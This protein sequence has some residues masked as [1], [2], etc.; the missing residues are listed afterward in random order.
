MSKLHTD[1]SFM[2][3]NKLLDDYETP[4]TESIT[5]TDPLVNRISWQSGPP[6]SSNPV[7]SPSHYGAGDIECID[8][9]KASMTSEAFKGYLKG[10]TEKYIWRYS[11]KNGIED[12]EKAKVY[13]NW[14]IEAEKDDAV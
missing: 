6:V 14:L 12:L 2:Y 13:L 8:A 5:M 3:E 9:I 11:Y 7:H 4:Q 10:N 1:E